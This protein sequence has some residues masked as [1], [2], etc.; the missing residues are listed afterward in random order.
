MAKRGKLDKGARDERKKRR[1]ALLR[2]RHDVEL[3]EDA[4]NGYLFRPRQCLYAREDAPAVEKILI[5]Q[6]GAKRTDIWATNELAS[7]KHARNARQPARMLEPNLRVLKLRRLFLPPDQ[8]VRACIGDLK[9]RDEVSLRRANALAPNYVVLGES[10]WG[11]EPARDPEPI[12]P[13]EAER[14]G[15]R[16]PLD[17]EAAASLT[18][19]V[20]DT[21]FDANADQH[22][23]LAGSFVLNPDDVDV[24][25]ADG[26]RFLDAEAGHGTFV[27]GVI[28]KHAPFVSLNPEAGLDPDGVGDAATICGM[29]A[30]L[31]RRT[32]RQGEKPCQI[33]NLSLGCFTEFDVP[34]PGLDEALQVCERNDVVV[35]A[36]AGNQGV[37]RRFY[38]AADERVIGVGA[39]EKDSRG[40]L[41]RAD[42]SNFGDWVDASTEGTDIEGLYV[43]GEWDP[44]AAGVITDARI[45]EGYARWTG[46]SFATPRVAA[47]IATYIAEH[48]DVSR[49]QAALDLIASSP[50]GPDGLGKYIA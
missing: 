17:G 7:R 38:P 19:G 2:D 46:T 18:V 42:Y 13:D 26:D 1:L 49:V 28:R 21:G 20:I 39:V 40:S 4:D 33:I 36:A 31:A 50:D 25:T 27:A 30:M 34:P 24:L 32:A 14:L 3:Q 29:I 12:S 10:W 22:P 9:S 8:S 6:Y 23:L 37:D 43:S 45:F 47:A 5:D 41:R 11:G 48:P 16:S 15:L 44:G 35:V